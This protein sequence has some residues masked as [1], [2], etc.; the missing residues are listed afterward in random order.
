VCVGARMGEGREK[1]RKGERERET[2]TETGGG[3]ELRALLWKT[4][5]WA[6]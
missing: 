6:R 4:L 3:N 1:E 5:W 2:E